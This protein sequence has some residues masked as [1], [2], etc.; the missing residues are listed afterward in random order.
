MLIKRCVVILSAVSMAPL[1]ALAVMT[2]AR[3][4]PAKE[5]L[6]AVQIVGHDSQVNSSRFVLIKDATTWAELWAEH[7]GTDA[8]ATPP[9]R[10]AVPKVD[11][12][13]FMVVGAFGGATT[14]TDG[15]VVLSVLADN[16]VLRIRYE[17]STFQTASF[18][19]KSDSGVKT[20][21]Y[22]LWV[23][24]KTD[25]LVVIEQATRGLKDSPIEWREVKRFDVN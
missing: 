2:A 17:A 7:T 18:D 14:N 13:R 12:G 9:M 22:G 3:Q 15:E 25:T 4:T 20:A 10:H 6:P 1:T 23:I 11:F 19:G 21:P 5:F 8:S 24:E 16:D